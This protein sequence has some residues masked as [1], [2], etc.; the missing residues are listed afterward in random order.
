[1][2]KKAW[3][4]APKVTLRIFWFVTK[5]M[6]LFVKIN[7]KMR[8]KYFDTSNNKGSAKIFNFFLNINFFIKTIFFCDFFISHELKLDLV[9]IF[10]AHYA[11]AILL[12]N[13]IFF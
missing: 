3:E 2:Q 1:M 10:E 9:N 5:R 12:L 13:S 4:N 8:T 6:V 11:G 7:L